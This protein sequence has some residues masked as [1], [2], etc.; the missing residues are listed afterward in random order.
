MNT[1][2]MKMASKMKRTVQKQLSR[3]IESYGGKGGS[4]VG[5]LRL[6]LGTFFACATFYSWFSHYILQK[7][8]VMVQCFTQ[9]IK[10][11]TSA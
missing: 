8:G 1:I 7:M 11:S 9:S 3:N 6:G 5:D 10:N 2:K 4:R